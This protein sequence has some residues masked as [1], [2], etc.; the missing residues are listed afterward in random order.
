MG[1]RRKHFPTQYGVYPGLIALALGTEP[2]KNIGVN[3]YSRQEMVPIVGQ[4]GS[5]MRMESFLSGRLR[6]S[7]PGIR[8]DLWRDATVHFIRGTVRKAAILPILLVLVYPCLDAALDVTPGFIGMQV[9]VLVL[10]ATLEP[11]HKLGPAPRLAYSETARQ[12]LAILRAA[13]GWLMPRALPTAT[14]V[15]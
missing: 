4:F 6:F 11:F 3:A 1:L 15:P 2:R 12:Y 13:E 8:P 14:V 7:E 10:Q 9:T 5:K